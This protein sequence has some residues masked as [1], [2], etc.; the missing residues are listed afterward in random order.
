MSDALL[1]SLASFG[2]RLGQ[3]LGDLFLRPGSSI[4]LASLACAFLIAAG[5]VVVKRRR[6]GKPASPRLILRAL[7]P[8]RFLA[9]PSGRADI[10]F[11]AFNTFAASVLFGWAIVSTHAV[12]V[13]VHDGLT[14]LVGASRPPPVSPWAASVEMTAALFL[15]YELGYWVDHYLKHRIPLLWEFHRVHHTAEHLSPLTNFRVHPVDSILFLNSLSLFI[16]GFHGAMTWGMGVP[17]QAI[18]LSGTNVLTLVF[19]FL[20]VHL[21]HSHIWIATRGVMGRL[22]QSP[23]HH[24]L[25]HSTNPAHFNTN[26]G[27]SLALFDWLFGTLLIPQAEPERLVFGVDAEGERPHSVEGAAITPFVRVWRMGRTQLDTLAPPIVERRS[28]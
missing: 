25:H 4:S 1:H 15:A 21:Q 6:G 20:L 16:G 14:H 17:A 26:F 24:Q 19:L 5:Y 2:Q 23:A 11:F 22:I 28:L 9:S 3:T 10:G 12:S 7:L 13:F 27:G 18:L 8:R